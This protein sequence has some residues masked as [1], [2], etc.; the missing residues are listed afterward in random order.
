[1]RRPLILASLAAILGLGYCDAQQPPAAGVAAPQ[2]AGRGRGGFGGPIELGPDDKPAFP[3]PPAGFNAKRDN[4]PHGELIHV[5][6]DSKSL[7]TRR[8]MRVYTPPGYSTARKYPVLYL[9]HG[10]GGTDTEWTASCHANNVIDNLLAEGKIQ[11]MVMVFP[12]GNSSRTVAD[13]AAGGRGAAPAAAPG[14]GAGRGRGMNMEAWLTPFENDL[15]KDIIPYVDSHYSVYTDRDHRAL[16]GL[17]MGGGQTLNIGL[18]HPETFAYVG[19]FSSAPD[20]RQPPSALVPDPSVPKQLK[21]VWLACGNKDGLIRISQAVHQYLK[22][23]GVS[24]VWHVDGNA[25]DT[26]EWDN[27]LYLFSQHIFT[28]A[29]LA[30]AQPPQGA[31]GGRGARPP[32]EIDKTPPVEDF[33]PSALNASINGQIRQYPEVNSQRRVR[34]RLRAPD[35]QNV[36]LDIGGVRYPMTKGEEGYWI[37]VS[38]AQDEGFHYYQLNVDGVSIPDPGTVM[39]YGASR[40]G[41]GVEVPAHDQDFY[42]RKNV[43]HGQLRETLYFSSSANAVLRSFV[44][45]PPDYDKDPSKRY[46]ALY[47]QHGGGEDETGWGQ[48]GRA[49][50]IIDNLIADGKA[51]PFI[52]VMANSYVPGA[53]FGFAASNQPPLADSSYART[54]SGPGGR[55]YNPAAFARVLI[56]DLVPY[57]DAT[58]RTLADQP[59]RAMAGLSMGG[60][61]TRSI[62]LAN[63]DKFSQIGVFSG[64]SIALTNITDMTVFKAKV[65][66]VFV[67]YGSRELGGDRINRGGDPRANTDAL[68]AAGVNAH[69]YVSPDTAHEWQSWRRSLHE[70]AP[71][72]FGNP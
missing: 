53:S 50:L 55:N 59:H 29:S 9:L 48:Q 5:E 14:A 15:L 69:F 1:M 71:L 44:Y 17:S 72:L 33:K 54:I 24:H 34:T 57:I 27:N 46:P 60:M 51:K 28:S 62:T 37:G 45:T 41:S 56:E 66:L 64:G 32:V 30:L 20:T 19:G 10:I 18:V 68:K 26:T 12:D 3:D 23:N 42:A 36:Q 43:P 65:Q 58:F 63:L 38:N 4:I 22:E 67:S 52:I 6:Y 70:L 25:H 47:L 61:Q 8:R 2:A 7:G 31:P 21:L 16:A 11:P 35:A 49:G 13:L 39:F 40:W